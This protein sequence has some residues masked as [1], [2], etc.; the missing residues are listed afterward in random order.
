MDAQGRITAASDGSGGGITA[1]TGDVTA[2]GSGSV[3]ATLATVNSNVGSFT[4][5]NITVNAK[6]LVTAAANGSG[7]S[8][9]GL[10]AGLITQPVAGTTFP[11]A[12]NGASSSQTALTN[13][14][15]F[16][17]PITSSE[18]YFQGFYNSE[19]ARCVWR[20]S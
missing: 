9:T 7:G 20:L 12:L 8:G 19:L 3:A 1:L 5:A 14:V 15:Q 16:F 17:M 11:H 10:W 6:G 4:S 2:S 18:N 13:G